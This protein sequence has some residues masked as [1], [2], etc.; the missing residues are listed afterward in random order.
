MRLHLLLALLILPFTA[1]AGGQKIHDGSITFHV[2]G[3]AAEAPKISRQV[4]TSA[5]KGFFRIIPEI[6]NRDVAAFST[7]P[8][9]DDNTYGLVLK[10]TKKGARK[11]DVI[12]TLHQNR[13]LLSI[14]DGHAHGIVSMT[15]PIKD[16]TL[17]IWR[18]VTI[19]QINSYNLSI[20]RI[21]ED[22]KT[23]KKRIKEI[24]KKM[25]ADMKAEKK[26]AKE[27]KKRE[28]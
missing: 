2:E 3:S 18:G 25:K 12:S 14:I 8:S 27:L 15:K 16:G 5:G 1:Y 4:E 17:V 11:L 21:G 13:L 6:S 24:K 20:P 19:K 7:F 23:W 22:P 10:L 28:Y 26:L 9:E